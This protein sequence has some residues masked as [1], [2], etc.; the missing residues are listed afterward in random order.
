MKSNRPGASVD[1][2]VIL[3]TLSVLPLSA[4]LRSTVAFAQD[5]GSPLPSW[6]DGPAKQAIIDF[7]RVTTDRA[8]PK[9]VPV[10]ERIAV[11]DQ[12]GTL[13]VEHPMY[14]F[15]T[16]CLERVPILVKTKPGLKEIEPFKTVLS[17]NRE[18]IS[19]LTTPD[20]EKILAAT[21][22]GM[23]VEE[24]K[25]EVTKWLDTAR[26]PRWNRPYTELVRRFL[27]ANDYRTYMS[28][29]RPNVYIGC[30]THNAPS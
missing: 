12:D 18:E 16:Y 13:W 9:F 20:L 19:K 2:R 14:T 17:G 10:S 11:F 1:R 27:R 8:S 25:A 4:V 23:S 3:S 22:T 7:V 6:N 15:M 29:G 30:S 26:H 5:A 28:R 24:F 21:V